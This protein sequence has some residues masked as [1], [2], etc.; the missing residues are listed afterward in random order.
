MSRCLTP[1][2]IK[3]WGFS[4]SQHTIFSVRTCFFG[5]PVTFGFL[6]HIF[7]PRFATDFIVEN[8][9]FGEVERVLSI[10]L[11]FW[12]FAHIFTPSFAAHF[13]TGRKRKRTHDHQQSVFHQLSSSNLHYLLPLYR[14]EMPLC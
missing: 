2:A 14:T 13:A 1:R 7:A 10:P 9:V 5:C 6:I 3:Y 4:F 12:F 11:A 8:A